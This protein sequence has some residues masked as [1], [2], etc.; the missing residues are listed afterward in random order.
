[1]TVVNHVMDIPIMSNIVQKHDSL[2]THDTVTNASIQYI[3]R[4]MKLLFL[5]MQAVLSYLVIVNDQNY[6][7]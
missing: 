4:S 1:M 2:Y 7:S 6:T 3:W 5:L